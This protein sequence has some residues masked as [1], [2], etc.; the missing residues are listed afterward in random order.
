MLPVWAEAEQD[1]A[2]EVCEAATEENCQGIVVIMYWSKI[3]REYI[4]VLK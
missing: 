3:D 4:G 2:R 1:V